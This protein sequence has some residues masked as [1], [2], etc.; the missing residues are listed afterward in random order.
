MV[1]EAIGHANG[2]LFALCSDNE[3]LKKFGAGLFL[4]FTFLKWMIFAFFVM[5]LMSIPA[6]YSNYNGIGL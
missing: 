4:F 2:V 6:L 3:I 1:M 5:S